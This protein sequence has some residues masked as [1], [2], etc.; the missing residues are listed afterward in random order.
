[1]FCISVGFRYNIYI[2]SALHSA[3]YISIQMRND[4]GDDKNEDSLWECWVI[5]IKFYIMS[6]HLRN[7]LPN[8]TD[9]YICSKIKWQ[10]VVGI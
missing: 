6:I 9:V 5:D 10:Y 8:P 3:R 1:M 2:K 7:P 4:I